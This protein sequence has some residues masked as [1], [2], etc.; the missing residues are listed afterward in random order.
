MKQGDKVQKKLEWISHK[1]RHPWKPPEKRD[2]GTL[3]HN[4]DAGTTWLVQWPWG[5]EWEH[6]DNLEIIS[7]G[8]NH[9]KSR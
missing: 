9:V 2:V 4:V 5:E 7:I 3:L 1:A 6:E 8:E